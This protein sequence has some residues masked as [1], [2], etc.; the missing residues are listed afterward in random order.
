MEIYRGD[1]SHASPFFVWHGWKEARE[2][3]AD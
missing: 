3:A 2:N 1:A